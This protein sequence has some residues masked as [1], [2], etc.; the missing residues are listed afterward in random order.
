MSKGWKSTALPWPFSRTVQSSPARP[1]VDEWVSC[2]AQR[3][4]THPLDQRGAVSGLL[5]LSRNLG[6]VTG[7]SVM[8][9][10]FALA[11]ATVD[12]AAAGPEAVATGMRVTFAVGAM[13]IVV[14]LAM[15][16]GSRALAT[17]PALA[18]ELS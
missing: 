10:V 6:L 15:A 17:R 1:R 9:A 13:L 11:S 8:A 12:V 14:A 4:Q 18:E 3:S 5:D 16:V 2:S 7:A